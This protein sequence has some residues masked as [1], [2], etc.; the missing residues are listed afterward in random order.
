MLRFVLAAA[1]FLLGLTG[2]GVFVALGYSAWVVRVEADRQLAD[3]HARAELAA[4]AAGRTLAVV[5][6]VIDRA[7]KDLAA[8]RVEAAMHP[9]KDDVNPLVR[10]VVSQKARSLPGKVEQARDAVGTASDAVVVAT[11]ALDVF[12]KLPADGEMFGVSPEQVQSARAQLDSVAA[13]LQSARGVLGVP[14]PG[15]DGPATAEQLSAVDDALSRARAVTVELEGV[16]T[17]VRTRVA[18]IRATAQ[19]WVWRAAVAVT[20]LSALAALGQVFMVR[21]CWRALRRKEW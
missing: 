21:A 17:R 1:G 3:A 18:E 8:A 4:D 9:R 6:D 5:H 14:I 20:G 11:A 7:G 12:R 19:V 16:L 10:M 15:P 2:V 13:D